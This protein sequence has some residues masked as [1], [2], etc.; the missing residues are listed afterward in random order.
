MAHGD[1]CRVRD[2]Y[3]LHRYFASIYGVPFM[4]GLGLVWW[5]MLPGLC[6]SSNPR[7]RSV[8]FCRVL[9]SASCRLPTYAGSLREPGVEDV[10]ICVSFGSA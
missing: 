8:I 5:I 6:S 10:E 7:G 3:P 2:R 1:Q 9:G 4:L